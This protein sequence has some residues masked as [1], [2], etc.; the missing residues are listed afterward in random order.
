MTSASHPVRTSCTASSSRAAAV[1][2]PG[3]GRHGVDHRSRRQ[4]R[5]GRRRSS[6]EHVARWHGHVTT[7]IA[8]TD[9]MVAA[10]VFPSFS[11]GN[12][13][14]GARPREARATFPARSAWARPTAPTRS[15]RFSS[16]GPVTWN[17]PPY[18]GTWIKPD[19]SAPGVKIYSTVPGGDWA[20]SDAGGEWSGT[21][22]AA[23]HVAGSVA[24]MI[25]ANPT[26]TVAT[27][28]QLLAADGDRP[29]RCRQGQRLRL[30]ARQRVHRRDRGPGRRRHPRRH[31]D[32]FG[33]R[34]RGQR[35]GA[36]HGHR[37]EGVHRRPRRTTRCSW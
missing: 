35:P 3:G 29:R 33:G 13:G 36:D 28:K 1:L 30:R 32:Q 14:P 19:M 16:R 7:M 9:N 23:P 15:R 22:M 2:R 18:V 11:I 8:P 21:S 27:I 6:R 10:G 24:L 34:P 17:T 12:S 37:P 25:Q 26:M 5:H 31:R 20:W 4:P